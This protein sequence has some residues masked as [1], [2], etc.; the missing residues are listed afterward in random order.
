MTVGHSTTRTR[1]KTRL[2]SKESPLSES[3]LLVVAKQP[4]VPTSPPPQLGRGTPPPSLE[5]NIKDAQEPLAI[6]PRDEQ[7]RPREPLPQQ[8]QL[9][10]LNPIQQPQ[11]HQL[12]VEQ[13]LPIQVNEINPEIS[14]QVPPAFNSWEAFAQALIVHWPAL[15]EYHGLDYENPSTY[16]TKCT[17]Y[18]T[19]L[20]VPE[21]QKQGWLREERAVVDLYQDVVHLG[22]KFC[23]T[24]P[25]IPQ[26]GSTPKLNSHIDLENGFPKECQKE[27]RTTLES[28]L[29]ILTPTPG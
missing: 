12:Q 6:E 19:A 18:C 25:L 8:Q 26:Q 9:V 1:S 22:K 14:N 4:V 3:P 7:H 15:P 27:V 23:C 28:H 10:Q 11:Q 29:H 21:A 20:Q 13:H 2:E 5:G 24:I 16:L 17:E